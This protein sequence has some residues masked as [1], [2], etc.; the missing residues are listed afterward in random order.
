MDHVVHNVF[1]PKILLT[2]Q[3][4]DHKAIKRS[5]FHQSWDGTGLDGV[6]AI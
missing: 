1:H 6:N 3:D 4:D 5:C 2:L